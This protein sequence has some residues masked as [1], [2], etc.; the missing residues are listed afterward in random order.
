MKNNG[1]ASIRRSNP[2]F[3]LLEM[4]ITIA[5]ILILVA[6]VSPS[7][8]THVYAVRIHYAATD[9]SGIL[10]RARMEA[11]RKNT[12]YSVQQV[13]VA[14]NV[15]EVFVDIAKTGVLAAADP[16]VVIGTG[17]TVNFGPG[18]GAPGEAAF[19][20][21]LNFAVAGAGA[22]PNFNA[23]GLPCIQVGATCPQTPGQGFIFFVSGT[24]QSSGNL[25][26]AA[27]AVTPSGR[28][29]VWVYDGANWTQQ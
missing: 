28:A 8:M 4:M 5:I 18:A 16:Q 6:V 11:S 22:V 3:S 19:I 2:G 29:Q 1:T 12:F 21:G 24:N 15:T 23:R 7:L 17:M 26:W 20:A 27:V 13:A 9:L 10:Q 25:G 14:G